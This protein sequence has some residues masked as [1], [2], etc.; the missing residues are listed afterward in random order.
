MRLKKIIIIL[1]SLL[2]LT[3]L[4]NKVYA[5]DFR[6]QY[7]VEYFLNESENYLN[8]KVKFNIKITNLRSDIYVSRFSIAF[9]NTFT[10][11]NLKAFDDKGE[12][13]P[14]LEKGQFATKIDMAFTEPNVG[15]DS[16]NNFY[17]EFNQDNLFKIN[18]NVWEVILPTMEKKED[19]I[20]NIIVHL[21]PGTDKKISIAKPKPTAISGN[22]ILWN[23]PATKTVYAVFGSEQLYRIS[24][25][26][27]LN[28]ENIYPVYT[29]VA[30]PPD[31]LYQKI[32]V[33]N[34]K[35]KPNKVYLDEDDNFIGRY[36]L[37]PKEKTNINFQAVIA[38]EAKPRPEYRQ[39]TKDSFQWQKKYLLS[40]QKFW[41]LEKISNI[42]FLKNLS[43]PKDIYKFVV[44][45]LSY[46]FD[47]AGSNNYK[48]VGAE[49]ALANPKDAVCTE[50]TDLFITLA[51]EKGIY[52]REIEGYAYSS[53]MRFRPLS[54]SSDVLHAWPEYYDLKDSLWIPID[55][56]WENTSGIDYFN[57]FDLNHIVFVIH[58]KK[59][60]Y[61]VPAGMYKIEDSK[62][63]SLIP[64]ADLPK[65]KI[66]LTGC[67]INLPQKINDS[68]KYIAK[69]EIANQG[70]VYIYNQKFTLK[71]NQL[72]FDQE[73]YDL[74]ILAPFEKKEIQFSFYALNKN[75]LIND[76]I[77]IFYQN[78][79]LSSVSIKIIPRLIQYLTYFSLGIFSFGLLILILR[80]KL[81]SLKKI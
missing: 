34:I 66:N 3:S 31:T 13:T 21:P 47:R 77:K 1:F 39:Y 11:T 78:N 10:I 53:D 17:L 76:E 41:Q 40:Q 5:D 68:S 58:G 54:L 36:Y 80:L 22:S 51:R 28:N 33:E 63:I 12:I 19:G 14:K 71:A 7:Q 15:K 62:D 75:K 70:N 61:P 72:K 65:E 69:F 30:F 26:Y 23:N 67:F 56:T 38:V 44:N 57:S 79:E 16:Q 35:P 74:P 46:N 29:E 60:D 73:N 48:R 42:D 8:T 2:F 6:A 9:P 64:T 50:F 81:K 32:Y 52:S 37:K 43:T 49:I 59:S 55:P 45:T 24:L 25:T 27:N 18:G 4:F 20:Y